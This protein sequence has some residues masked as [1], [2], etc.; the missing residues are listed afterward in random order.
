[1]H[2][3]AQHNTIVG[4]LPMRIVSAPSIAAWRVTHV[5]LPLVS[6]SPTPLQRTTDCVLLWAACEKKARIRDV[7][8]KSSPGCMVR[9]VLS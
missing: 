8:F 4:D 2:S 9:G 1:M 5:V 7:D 6:I 3:T